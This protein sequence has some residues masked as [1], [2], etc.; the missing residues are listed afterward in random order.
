M[1]AVGAQRSSTGQVRITVTNKSSK[2]CVLQGFP[3]VAIAGQ[4]SPGKNKPLNVSRQGTARA[5]QLP[6]GGK[7]SAQ[8]TFT[9]VLGEAEGSCASGA[10]P[11]V[12]PSLVIGVAGARFQLAPDDGGD[13]ALCGA[14]VRA[15]AFR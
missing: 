5:V 4:G 3:T 8:L 15:T 1:V 10:D 12:A 6:A 9:P 14:G 2:Q 7:A 11:T 13:F